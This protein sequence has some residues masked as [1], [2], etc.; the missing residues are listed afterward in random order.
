MAESVQV[1]LKCGNQTMK[2]S[3]PQNSQIV[4]NSNLFENLKSGAVINL[5][6]EEYAAFSQLLGYDKNK[7][8]L[9]ATDLQTFE[10][11]NKAQQTEAINNALKR[12]G[13]S[14][15]IGNVIMD[16]TL[17]KANIHSTPDGVA[18]NMTPDGKTLST[19][20]E[21]ANFLGVYLNNKL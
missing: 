11:L 5:N 14:S 15:R 1:T 3:I 21:N 9:T 2:V 17:E 20:D 16:E 13:S 18:I 7:T 8:D 10:K 19:H 12:A 4:T 6:K